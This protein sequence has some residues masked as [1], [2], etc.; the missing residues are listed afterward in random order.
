VAQHGRD[1]NAQGFSGCTTC[2]GADLDGGSVGVSCHACHAAAGFS[3]WD[4]NCTFCHGDPASGGPSP[5]VDIQGRSVATNVSVGVHASHVGTAIANPIGCG[6][7]HPPRSASVV[8]DAAHVDGNGLAEVLFG[9]IATTGGAAATYTRASDTSA[10]CAA[11]YC[12]GAFAG[13]ANATMGWTSTAQVG[14]TSC[15]GAPPPAPHTASTSCGTCHPGY[16]QT[17]VIAATHVDGILQVTSNHAAGYASRTAHGYD[18]NLQGLTGCKSCHGADLNGGSGP[19]CTACHASAGFPSW[20]TTC[21]FCHGSTTTGRQNPPVDV[22]GRTVATNVSVG[23]H[24]SHATT[25]IANP[26]ACTECHPARTASVVTDA[27]HLDG[28]GIAEIAFGTIARTGNVT[29]AYTRTS[30]TAATCASTYCHG[31]FSG[32]VNGGSGATM[33]WTSTTQV[34]CT[35]CHGRPPSTG[36]HGD[37]SGRSCGDCH[38]GYTTS[39]V[40]RTTHL[41]GTKQVGNRITSW[42]PS[43][44]SC[45]SNCHGSETW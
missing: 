40:N 41:N 3:T 16:T 43:T 10:S 15:H 12:H 8:T 38:P 4:T 42:N 2:H 27:A 37:H 22:R 14:C 34:G 9:P 1:A 13:G 18:A 11:T 17:T 44:R 6:Q 30:A 29:P 23:V 36:N 21:T 25:T 28:N 31:R 20:A 33:G 26:I 35:S 7:C 32:G 24:E 19:S 39:S 5:P 45:S